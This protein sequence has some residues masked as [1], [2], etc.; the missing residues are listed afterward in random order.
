MFPDTIE[1]DRLRLERLTRDRVDPRTLYEAASD[2]SPTVDEETEY[3]PW[4]PLATL[5]DAEDRIAA[6]ERQWAERE[7]AEWAIRPR[8]GEDGAGEFAGT[9]GLICRWDEDLALP[10]I[11]LRKPFWGRR[12]SGSGPTRS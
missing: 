11:W 10:A 8:E 4:S 1:T 5:R 7:R 9:A 12:Y 6:F 3:L 2:R